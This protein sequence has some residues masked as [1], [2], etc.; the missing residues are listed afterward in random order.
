MQNRE[1]GFCDNKF[2][3]FPFFTLHSKLTETCVEFQKK[4]VYVYEIYINN[5]IAMLV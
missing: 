5:Y 4:C 2:N 1:W 3:T